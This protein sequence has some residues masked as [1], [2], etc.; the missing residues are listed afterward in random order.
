VERNF[1]KK[2]R[3]TGRNNHD[4]EYRRTGSGLKPFPG[5]GRPRD[6]ELTCLRKE[7]RALREASD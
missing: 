6:E 1:R 2:F 5:H 4:K 7:N 3:A